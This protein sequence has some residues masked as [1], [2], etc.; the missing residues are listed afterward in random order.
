MPGGP[1]LTPRRARTNIGPMTS[2]EFEDAGARPV[3]GRALPG[4]EVLDR[5]LT[6]GE[7]VLDRELRTRLN[8]LLSEL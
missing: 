2:P 6:Y 4:D 3:S 5:T 1:R 8:N 7:K